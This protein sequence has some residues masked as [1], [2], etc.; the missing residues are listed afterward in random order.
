MLCDRY[1][2]GWCV[3]IPQHM[4]QRKGSKVV[5]CHEGFLFRTFE[6]K[7]SGDVYTHIK[8]KKLSSQ[9]TAAVRMFDK[10]LCHTVTSYM[11]MKC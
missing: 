6:K 1:E 11:P 8:A 10:A 3:R 5:N 9:L 4:I 2:L 7:P